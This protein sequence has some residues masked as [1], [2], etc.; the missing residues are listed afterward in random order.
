MWVDGGLFLCKK[1]V[2]I[3][4]NELDV[5]V[6][7]GWGEGKWWSEVIEKVAPGPRWGHAVW[8]RGPL[9]LGRW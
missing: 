6:T 7:E 5:G 8:G 2:W 1:S 9:P 3:N 4:A